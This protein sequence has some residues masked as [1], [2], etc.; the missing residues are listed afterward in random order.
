[1]HLGKQQK[2]AW[3]RGICA[4]MADLDESPDSWRQ[5]YLALAITAIWAMNQ[6]VQSLT[7]SFCLLLCFPNK[8]NESLKNKTKQK[9]CF[10]GS[11][12]KRYS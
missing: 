10:D 1:M 5:L 2:M 3:N 9:D 6:P 12:A 7:L 4:H 8:Q 11:R